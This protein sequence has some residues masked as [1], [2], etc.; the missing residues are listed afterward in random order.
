M[1]SKANHFRRGLG[2]LETSGEEL[3]QLPRM[4]NWALVYLFLV[5][6]S[7]RLWILE[8]EKWDFLDQEE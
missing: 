3:L 2:L 4:Y 8:Q 5:G 1:W 7:L 6:D